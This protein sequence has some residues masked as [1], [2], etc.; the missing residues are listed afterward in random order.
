MEW[1]KFNTHGESCN[2]AFEVMC[3]LLFEA[4]CKK[5]YG[6]KIANFAFIN[7]V[8]GDGGIEAYAALEN[9]DVIGVQSKWFRDKIEDNQIRQI[10]S[11]F[12]TAIKVRPKIIRYIVCIPRDLGSKRIVKGGNISQNTEEDR[13]NKLLSSLEGMAPDVKVELWNETRIQELITWP[14]LQGIHSFWFENSEI[15][16]DRFDLSYKKAIASW[17][18]TKYIPDLYAEGYIHQK[19]ERFLGSLNL[20]EQRYQEWSRMFNRLSELKRAFEDLLSLDFANKE[21]DLPS[22]IKKDLSSIDEWLSM[23]ISA[24]ESVKRGIPVC[25][26][27]ELRLEC[28]IELLKNSLKLFVVS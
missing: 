25:F 15:F 2:H 16:V 17:A 13:W 26:D 12:S 18:K 8:G 3:N 9:G 21:I 1:T 20:T 23:L 4:W 27:K 28:T 19:L 6:N 22:K 5:E 7:G 24:E 10:E 11:S 14:E